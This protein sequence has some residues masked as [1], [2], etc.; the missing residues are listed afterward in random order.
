M[1][2]RRVFFQGGKLQNFAYPLQIADDEMQ[3]DV[4]KRFYPFYRISLCWLNFK[5][6][7]CIWNVFY[8][9]AI[10]KAFSFYELPNTYFVEHFLQMII[11]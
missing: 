6:Q 11:I 10:R 2:V 3:I 9:S 4:H 8:F 7:S 5:S 1:G